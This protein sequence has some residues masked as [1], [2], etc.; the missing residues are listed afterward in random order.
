MSEKVIVLGASANPEKYS[1]K[2]VELLKAHGHEVF[3]VHPQAKEVAGVSVYKDLDA[4]IA[5]GAVIDTMSLYV[6]PDIS[7]TL[8]DKFLE[9]KPK[10]V[11]FNPGS[12]NPDLEK[13]LST[14][15]IQTLE[16][17]TLVMLKTGQY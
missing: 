12:E 3:P 17:C 11:I 5:S 7:N 2:A 10:R 9:I 15:G 1:Y 13:I 16:A 8:K 14:N 6:G 4:V